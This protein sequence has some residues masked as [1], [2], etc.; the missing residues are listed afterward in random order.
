MPCASASN[1]LIPTGLQNRFLGAAAFENCIIYSVPLLAPEAISTGMCFVFHSPSVQ[2]SISLVMQFRSAT[3][4]NA[5]GASAFHRLI[6][7]SRRVQCIKLLIEDTNNN[8]PDSQLAFFPFV[9]IE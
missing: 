5:N 3:R 8:I 4:R 9:W 6:L 1:L 7:L 2:F